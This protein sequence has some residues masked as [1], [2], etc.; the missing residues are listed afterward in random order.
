MTV[1][2]CPVLLSGMEQ[3]TQEIKAQAM[4]LETCTFVWT[5]ENAA[6]KL[7]VGQHH[8]LAKTKRNKGSIEVK[9][10][11]TKMLVYS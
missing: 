5:D 11:M 1:G 10:K 8:Y 2:Q 7:R 4:F 3:Q 9:E 6:F